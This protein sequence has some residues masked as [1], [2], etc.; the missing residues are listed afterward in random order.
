MSGETGGGRWGRGWE[1]FVPCYSNFRVEFTV[2]GSVRGLI[3][4]SERS[5]EQNEQW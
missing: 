5:M 1:E 3:G 2:V 4:G